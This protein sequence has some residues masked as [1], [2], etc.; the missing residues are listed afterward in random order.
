MQ[1][2]SSNK[3][4]AMLLVQVLKINQSF[5]KAH[6]F[7]RYYLSVELINRYGVSDNH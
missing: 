7:M 3:K 2:K 6:F 4:N 1:K 5:V